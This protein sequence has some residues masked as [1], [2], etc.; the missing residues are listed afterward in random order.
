MGG[1]IID[2]FG[3]PEFHN[4]SSRTLDGERDYFENYIWDQ[5]SHSTTTYIWQDTRPDVSGNSSLEG[6]AHD[7]DEWLQSNFPYYDTS[8]CCVVLDYW[9]DSGYYGWATGI[10]TNGD[11]SDKTA[12]ID[13]DSTLDSSIDDLLGHRHYLGMEV[14]HIFG[15]YHRDASVYSDGDITLMKNPG[16]GVNCSNNGSEEYVRAEFSSCADGLIENYAD[17]C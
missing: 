11:A 14:G 8:G 13:Y 3:T 17:N 9:R 6:R 5:I 15:C 16:D 10:G 12:N 7:Q 2:F 1:C 4:Q